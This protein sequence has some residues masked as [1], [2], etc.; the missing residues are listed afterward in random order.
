[1]STPRNY[2]A[3]HS[4]MGLSYTLDSP[5]YTA[6]AF[7]SAAARDAWVDAHAYED[8]NYTARIAT[9]REAYRVAGINSIHKR[10]LLTQAGEAKRL[11]AAWV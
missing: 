7:D 9:R 1:M 10:P 5:C 11:E 4:N 3:V 8:G 6:Y 2:Y